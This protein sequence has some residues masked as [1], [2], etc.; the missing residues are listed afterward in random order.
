[1][2]NREELVGTT[3]YLTLYASCRINRCRYNR[4]R[5]YFRM[6]HAKRT[7]C[8]KRTRVGI[9]TSANIIFNSILL[10]GSR[11]GVFGIVTIYGLDR[12]GFESR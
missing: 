3:E 8:L 10:T 6:I 11:R 4:V 12:P 7:P 5:L 1:M 9:E 2:V